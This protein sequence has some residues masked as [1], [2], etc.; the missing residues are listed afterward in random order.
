MAFAVFGSTRAAILTGGAVGVVPGVAA[1]VFV[2][3]AV[4]PGYYC[5]VGG[6]VDCDC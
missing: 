2:F 4:G 6:V 3:W 5:G 1:E